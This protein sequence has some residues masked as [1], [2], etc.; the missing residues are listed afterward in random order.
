MSHTTCRGTPALHGFLHA[1]WR[2][3]RNT[4][5]PLLPPTRS[6]R[7]KWSLCAA[8]H[9]QHGAETA[10]AAAAE[11]EATTRRQ[12]LAA[13]AATLA[14]AGS[15]SSPAAVLAAGGIPSGFTAVQDQPDNYA[16]LYPFG[17]QEVSIDGVDVCYKDVIEPLESVSVTIVPTKTAKLTDLGAPEQVCA[18]PRALSLS[19]PALLLSSL[20][21]ALLGISWRPPRART[22]HV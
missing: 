20:V 21:T 8:W 10:A 6:I 13:T 11:A 3:G 14:A 19:A 16:F 12:V 9:A 17:W 18:G 1:K 22:T 4:G 7:N 2:G 15:F 5:P